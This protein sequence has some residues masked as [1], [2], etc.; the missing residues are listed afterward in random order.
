MGAL[1]HHMYIEI[2]V[3][4]NTVQLDFPNPARYKNC[5]MK[6]DDQQLPLSATW[7]EFDALLAASSRGGSIDCSGDTSPACSSS[8]YA[9]SSSTWD[10]NG[11]LSGAKFRIPRGD[12]TVW[13]ASCDRMSPSGLYQCQ[14]SLT[15]CDATDSTWRPG[16]IVSLPKYCKGFLGDYRNQV[17]CTLD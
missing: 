7:G 9:L 11:M 5:I 14:V 8:Y 4:S 15:T 1:L 12:D 13:D 17:Q 6:I 3:N 16:L 2:L 10:S